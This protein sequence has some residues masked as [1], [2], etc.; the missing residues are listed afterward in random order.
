MLAP[1]WEQHA[2]AAAQSA[3]ATAL[4]DCLRAV[5]GAEQVR[6]APSDGARVFI[7][8]DTRQSSPELA[9]CAALGVR[10]AGVPAMHI[11]L[12]TTPMLHFVVRE[13]ADGSFEQYFDTLLQGFESLT[14]GMPRPQLTCTTCCS[15]R[16]TF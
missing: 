1:D 5:I 13:Q 10:L 15:C 3:D 9:Q 11:G 4:Q 2:T 7:G 6:T 12:C 8:H 14:A 16:P